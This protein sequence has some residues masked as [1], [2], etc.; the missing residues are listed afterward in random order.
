TFGYTRNSILFLDP[1]HPG[2]EIVSNIQSDP[3]LY[4]GG[5]GRIPLNWQALDNFSFIKSNHTFKGGAN[6]RWYAIDQFR[7]ATNF[8]PRLTF[9]TA[10]APVFLKTDVS[11]PTLNLTGINSNDMTRLNS[12]FN[13]LMGVVGTVQKVYYSNGTSFPSADNELKFLQRL[14]EYNFYFQDDW[15]VGAKLTVNLGP[16]SEFNGVPFDPSGLQVGND[17]PLNSPSGDVALLPAGPGTGR[18]W[19]KNDYTNF[20]PVVGFAWSPFGDSKT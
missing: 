13:D 14:R 15:R 9:G 16:R 18:L 5:T 19:Y 6:L 4:W 7:R 11:S 20:A 1:T 8:Y 3:Y 2:F 17:K 10:N 12:L